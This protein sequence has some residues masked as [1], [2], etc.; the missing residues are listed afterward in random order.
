ME[1]SVI[2]TKSFFSI[3]LFAQ[4]DADYNFW[5][6]DCGSQG[7]ISDG[8]TFKHS[9]LYTLIDKQHLNLRAPRSLQEGRPEIPYTILADEAFPLMENIMKPYAGIGPKGSRE[10]IYNY[11]LSGCWKRFWDH[12]FSFQTL[13]TAYTATT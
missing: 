13:E 6:V 1:A 3:V 9:K 12:L 8:G 7:R 11:R 2:T 4:I 10:R 5:Y